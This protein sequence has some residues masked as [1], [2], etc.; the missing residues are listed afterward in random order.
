[1]A[2]FILEMG[3]PKDGWH[4]TSPAVGSVFCYRPRVGKD[5]PGPWLPPDAASP[6]FG[7]GARK[8]RGLSLGCGVVPRR[9]HAGLGL[10]RQDHASLGRSLGLATAGESLASSIAPPSL[11]S[12][13]DAV[14]AGGR[15]LHA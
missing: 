8:S 2:D 9:S 11:F 5:P 7:A 6:L 1:M 12:A 13:R 4:L 10:S 3:Y 14:K 15:Q